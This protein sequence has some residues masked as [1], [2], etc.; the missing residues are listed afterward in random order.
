MKKLHDVYEKSG[1]IIKTK[2]PQVRFILVVVIVLMPVL[3][4]NDILAADYLFSFIEFLIMGI[5]VF[6]LVM[7]YRGK[8]RIASFLP[9]VFSSVAVIS[10]AVLIN[11]SSYQQVF[12]ITVYM[13]VLLILSLSLGE[14]EWYTL[15]LAC[16]GILT[17][18][19]VTLL[20]IGPEVIALG[21]EAGI[22]N[23][24]VAVMIFILI[25]IFCFNSARSGRKAMQDLDKS[26]QKSQIR[27]EQIMNVSSQSARSTE[28]VQSILD[29]YQSVE[30]NMGHIRKQV[31]VFADSSTHL[32]E[33]ISKALKAVTN[34]SEQILEFHGKVD[35]QN[36]VVEE[37]TSAV[38]EMSAS[39]DSVANITADKQQSSERLMSILEE[40]RNALN[41]TNTAIRGASDQMNSLLEINEII[42]D[43]AS[44][45]DLLSMNAAIEAAHAGEHGR[46]FAVVAEEIRKLANS[47]G[48]NSR[49]ISEK[50]KRIKQS[51]ESTH[52]TAEKMG[53]S[54]DQISS[55]V[56]DVTL[57]F[58][59]ITGSTAE[60]SSG[61]KE[62]MSAMQ[63]LQDN[64]IMI[65]E[66]SERISGDQQLA[67]KEMEQ[68]GAVVSVIE[69]ASREIMTA[70]DMIEQSIR[71]LQNTIQKSSESSA[72]LHQSIARLTE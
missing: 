48:E 27:I 37:S 5:M 52:E 24:I 70:V 17:I 63:T 42:S 69:N 11:V 10:L 21:L 49:I 39:L 65:R 22:D 18:V 31:E 51:I 55:E 56:N 44:R 13:A 62:I 32:S 26:N 53:T 40:G 61:G 50:M 1:I 28:S 43:I 16:V 71:H 15:V 34:T 57:A 36:V 45:T 64:S 3:I 4:L 25:S 59:E 9:L 47:T 60:L 2:V 38:H 19:L 46:G 29:D 23:L 35:E 30:N 67:G 72:S 54:M 14:N 58:Q 8:Y 20:K 12:T 68:V 6:S 33:N 66:G 7:L 41:Q